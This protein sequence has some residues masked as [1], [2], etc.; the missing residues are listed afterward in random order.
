MQQKVH[1]PLG[2]KKDITASIAL[3]NA[4]SLE[5]FLAFTND[6]W[7]K[8]IVQR[9]PENLQEDGHT[10]FKLF[11]L[12]L[13]VTGTSAWQRVLE[14]NGVDVTKSATCTMEK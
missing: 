2:N 7:E 3:C 10:L 5:H 8:Q 11:P 9:L 12:I 6:Q 1:C 13:G 14:D 4:E